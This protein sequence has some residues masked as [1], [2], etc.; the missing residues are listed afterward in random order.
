MAISPGSF[1]HYLI[2][3]LSSLRR[4]MATGTLFV[5]L[6]IDAVF[7][8]FAKCLLFESAEMIDQ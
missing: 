4:E 6:G 7:I 5:S 2:M 1:R 3:V 8:G